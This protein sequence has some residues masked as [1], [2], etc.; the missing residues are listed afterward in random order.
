MPARGPRARKQRDC[1]WA[2]QC[3]AVDYAIETAVVCLEI[4]PSPATATAAK[5]KRKRGARKSKAGT[6]A[7]AKAKAQA[8]AL[9]QR[10]VKPLKTPKHPHS[11]VGM[12]RAVWTHHLPPFPARLPLLRGVGRSQGQLRREGVRVRHCTS[13]SPLCA[14]TSTILA[15]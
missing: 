5:A 1:G 7:A 6:S 2:G 13:P 4:R 8:A 11:D 14:A 12:H 3:V 10:L 15:R 9:A